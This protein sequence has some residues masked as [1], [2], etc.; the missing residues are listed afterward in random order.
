MEK[1]KSILQKNLFPPELI[2]KVEIKSGRTWGSLRIQKISGIYVI[3]KRWLG[4]L[5][6][7]VRTKE[8]YTHVKKSGIYVIK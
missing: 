3:K 2:D 4:G 1:T 8:S 6:S 5:L 7:H